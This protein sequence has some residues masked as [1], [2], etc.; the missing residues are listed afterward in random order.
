MEEQKETGESLPTTL[1]QQEVDVPMPTYARNDGPRFL[2]SNPGFL[3]VLSKMN[4]CVAKAFHAYVKCNFNIAQT[5]AQL[6]ITTNRLSHLLSRSDMRRALR[7]YM[8]AKGVTLDICEQQL[9]NIIQN[10]DISD[11]DDYLNDN[12]G[13]LKEL[14]DKGID[15][16]MVAEASRVPG[17][18]GTAVKIRLHNKIDAIKTVT[19]LLNTRKNLSDAQ[20]SGDAAPP[21]KVMEITERV[22]TVRLPI[23]AGL[24]IER[25]K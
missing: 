24:K 11:Y 23:P 10:A 19:T 17:K 5:A 15:T 1:P 12:V 16:S 13:S 25:E 7:L 2:A 8:E 21:N 18:F 22:R 3:D 20:A 14:K 9:L 4:R 6:Q